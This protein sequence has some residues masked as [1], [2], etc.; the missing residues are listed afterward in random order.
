[1]LDIRDHGGKYGGSLGGLRIKSIQKGSVSISSG[2]YSATQTISNVDLSKAVIKRVLI[3]AASGSVDSNGTRIKFNG[4]TQLAFS[5]NGSYANA[6][7]VYWEVIEFED[8]KIQ[9]GESLVN[10]GVA[11]A[12]INLSTVDPNKC[13]IYFSNDYNTTVTLYDRSIFGAKITSPNNLLF[14]RNAG[15]GSS[16]IQWFVIETI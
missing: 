9:S 12:D 5:R 7:V 15:E 8:A 4:P 6:I 13:L 2:I 11:S 1:M 14:F 10:N 16:R 3:Y